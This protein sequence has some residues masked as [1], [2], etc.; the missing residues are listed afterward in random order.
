MLHSLNGFCGSGPGQCVEGGIVLGNKKA[1]PAR[2]TRNGTLFTSEVED[3]A[4]S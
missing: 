4:E 3:Q 1:F 2:P